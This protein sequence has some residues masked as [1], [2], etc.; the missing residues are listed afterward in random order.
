MFVW[1]GGCRTWEKEQH[2]LIWLVFVKFHY[3][4]LGVPVFI[5]VSMF[6]SF[7][8]HK[9][10]DD[11]HITIYISNVCLNEVVW[12]PLWKYAIIA[13]KYGRNPSKYKIHWIFLCSGKK[14]IFLLMVLLVPKVLTMCSLSEPLLWFFLQEARF[15]GVMNGVKLS[16]H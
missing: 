12:H 11:W 7:S 4:V 5:V 13:W 2:V 9:F 10:H 8:I 6:E 15:F 1:D 16:F 14:V 3:P